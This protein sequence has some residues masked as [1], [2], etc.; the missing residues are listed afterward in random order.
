M[1]GQTEHLSVEPLAIG[2]P[3]EVRNRFDGSWSAGFEVDG[4]SGGAYWLRR[5]SDGTLLPSV[6]L[7]DDVRPESRPSSEI[8]LR[9]GGTSG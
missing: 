1:S 3:V 4:I 5:L 6:F 8:D 7:N 2:T 9:S